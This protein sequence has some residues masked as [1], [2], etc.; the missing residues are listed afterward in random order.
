MLK[1]HFSSHFTISKEKKKFK[2]WFFYF[3]SI[4]PDLLQALGLSTEFVDQNKELA[5]A[6]YLFYVFLLL[7]VLILWVYQLDS[8]L[9]VTLS[10]EFRW[11]SL[12]CLATSGCLMEFR[13]ILKIE[14]HIFL[15]HRIH[16]LSDKVV[17]DSGA[18]TAEGLLD[19]SLV[20]FEICIEVSLK[21]KQFINRNK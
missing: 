20:K 15:V 5:A 6:S 14:L 17:D 21:S 2:L 3:V 12:Y 7:C 18:S 13:K 8:F 16:L 1:L 10:G 19:G 11:R 4:V 9:T